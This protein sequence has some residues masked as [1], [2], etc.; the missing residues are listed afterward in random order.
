MPK[1][2]SVRLDYEKFSTWLNSVGRA[3][4][5]DITLDP[6]RM[7]AFQNGDVLIG[8][9]NFEAEGNNAKTSK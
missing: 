9:F 4:Y 5:L 1:Q 8:G 3:D 7:H 6:L 2:S